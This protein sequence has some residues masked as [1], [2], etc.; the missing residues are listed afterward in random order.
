[1]EIKLQPEGNY[2]ITV[3]DQDKEKAATM[4][5]DYLLIVNDVALKLFQAEAGA[6]RRQLELR[7][8]QTNESFSEVSDSLQKFLK[9]LLFSPEDQAKAFSTSISDLKSEMIKQ[10]INLELIK[11]RY[12]ANDATTL[13]QQKAV[14]ELKSKIQS[15]QFEPGFAGNFTLKNATGVGVEYL[16]LIPNWKPLRKSRPSFFQCSKKPN[17]MK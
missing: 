11:N 10:E 12:G 2:T 14:D 13:L 15:T 5:R 16:R 17:S 3:W 7:I 8:E 9:I 6:N 1:M 4:T